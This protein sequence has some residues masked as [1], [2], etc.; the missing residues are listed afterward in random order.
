VPLYEYR[1]TQCGYDFERIQKF[2]EKPLT[3]CPKCQGELVRPMTAPALQFKG[4]GWY[5]NDY[6]AKGSAHKKAVT[7]ESTSAGK[8]DAGTGKTESTSA[9]SDTKSSESKSSGGD[10]A[11]AA[12]A[13]APAAAAKTA[14][15]ASK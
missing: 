14:P 9:G 2:S 11:A 13:A 1:C 12:T 6:S 10:T 3:E 15:A 5:I 8:A 4:S 7:A